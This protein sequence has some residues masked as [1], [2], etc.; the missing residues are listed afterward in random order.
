MADPF[1]GQCYALARAFGL[2]LRE[3]G[4]ERG[5][6]SADLGAQAM[7]MV[8]NGVYPAGSAEQPRHILQDSHCRVLAAENHEQI[9]KALAVREASPA[10]LR[11]VVL[12]GRPRVIRTIPPSDSGQI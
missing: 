3:L 1:W 8:G 7:G 9:D 12:A 5:E 2:A 11:I 6:V 10:L 4:V